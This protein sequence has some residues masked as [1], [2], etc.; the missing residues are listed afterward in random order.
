[1]GLLDDARQ[2][3][4]VS[5]MNDGICVYCDMSDHSPDCPWLALPRIVAALEA[6]E[7][8][9]KNGMKRHYCPDDHDCPVRTLRN[10]LRGEEETT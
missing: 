1:M 5:P 9:L 2:L 6:A 7:R 3:T 10:A 4:A 8:L